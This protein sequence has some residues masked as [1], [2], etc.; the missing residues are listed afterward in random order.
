MENW[1]AGDGGGANAASTG[2]K[3]TNDLRGSHRRRSTIS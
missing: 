2:K 3:A 1:L